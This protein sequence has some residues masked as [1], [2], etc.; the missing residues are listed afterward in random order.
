[1]VVPRF[2]PESDLLGDKNLYYM[3]KYIGGLIA[4]QTRVSNDIRTLLRFTPYERFVQ[5][6]TRSMRKHE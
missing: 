2:G 1:M 5:K 6:W 4:S 3:Q